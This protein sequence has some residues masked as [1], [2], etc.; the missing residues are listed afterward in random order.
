MEDFERVFTY[1]LLGFQRHFPYHRMM[2]VVMM[3]M[4]MMTTGT[5]A[6]VCSFY[7][8]VTT[9]STA[10]ELTYS[11]VITV[12]WRLLTPVYRW[13]NWGTERLKLPRVTQLNVRG[14][15]GLHSEAGRV[16]AG[17][18]YTLPF[19]SDSQICSNGRAPES[20]SA[21]AWRAWDAD[22]SFHHLRLEWIRMNS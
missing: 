5:S 22:S 8:P 1:S 7:V 21:L 15:S 13:G 14:G 19:L 6:H 12:L 3:M 4:M 10:R 17:Y 20:Q 11:V 2:I 18:C 9:L 16:S